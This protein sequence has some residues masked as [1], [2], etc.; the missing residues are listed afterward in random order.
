M[1]GSGGLCEP[2]HWSGRSSES[3]GVGTAQELAGLQLAALG[4]GSCFWCSGRLSR[5]ERW[6]VRARGH[7]GQGVPVRQLGKVSWKEKVFAA[8]LDSG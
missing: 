1:Q 8:T 4:Q 6:V 5:G 2:W 7:L 3:A